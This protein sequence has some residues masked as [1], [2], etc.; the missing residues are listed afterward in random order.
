MKLKVMTYNIRSGKNLQ[1]QLNIDFSSSVFAQHTPDFA[2]VN[3]V[4]NGS[5]DVAGANQ[6]QQLGERLDMRWAFG[7]A[8]PYQ[9]G[10]YGNAFLSKHPIL[11]SEVIDIPDCPPE[12]AP[13]L[14][15]R[16]I[17]KNVIEMEGQ[18][19]CVLTSH[20]GLSEGEHKQAV[21]TALEVIAAADMPV[22]LM[23][24]FNMRPDNPILAPLFETLHDT[25]DRKE[26]LGTYPSDTP[27]RKIDYIFVSD[28]FKVLSLVSQDIQMS[29]HRP[30]IA[31][32]EL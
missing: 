32:L 2:A 12:I 5:A 13:R 17:F 14:E 27:D 7:R 4:R 20:F 6:A 23:G 31:E 21:K 16:V 26:S 11:S 8:I 15:H 1:N 24:D 3:E 9:G 18:P 22:V 10:A 29:D 28:H 19:I 30:L 25:A